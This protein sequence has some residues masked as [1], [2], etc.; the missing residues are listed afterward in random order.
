M[1]RKALDIGVV[2]KMSGLPASTLRYYEE[3]G[4]IRSVGR[5]G[6]R[7]VFS[8]SVIERLSLISLGRYAG[9]SLDEIAMMF[10]PDGA[11]RIDRRHLLNKAQDL[12]KLIQRLE[13][14][15][16]GLEHVAD[17]PKPNQLECPRFRQLMSIAAKRQ[18]KGQK[19]TRHVPYREGKRS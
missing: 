1:G 12:G 16:K 11:L 6:I 19:L 10:S 3:K 18:E 17:C 5:D 8:E 9:L 14:M 7:R 4:L 15:K 13:A 2:A